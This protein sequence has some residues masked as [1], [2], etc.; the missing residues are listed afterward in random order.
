MKKV[1][2]LSM[3][4]VFAL[5]TFSEKPPKL[6]KPKKGQWIETAKPKSIY[7]EWEWIETDCCGIRHGISTPLSTGDNIALELKSDNTFMEIHTKVNALPRSGILSLSKSDVSDMI[8]FNDERP[9][10]Y[11]LSDNNDTLTISWKY[12]ELQTEKYTRTKK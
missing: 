3:F 10:R 5:V 1:F 12:L 4:S 8:Q 6:P 7:G 2:I 11:F 9:A